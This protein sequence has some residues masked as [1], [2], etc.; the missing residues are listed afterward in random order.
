MLMGCLLEDRR[1]T[2]NA[3][4]SLRGHSD[5]LWHST[6]KD[7]SPPKNAPKS[8]CQNCKHLSKT[9]KTSSKLRILFFFAS[10]NTFSL[11]WKILL[12]SLF[13]KYDSIF[14]FISFIF[15]NAFLRGFQNNAIQIF[16][17]CTNHHGLRGNKPAVNETEVFETL[18][19]NTVWL[20]LCR[21]LDIYFN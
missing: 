4:L 14:T 9:N 1:G 15:R 10:I 7:S 16:S 6:I 12:F 17:S 20:V 18:E 5:W 11:K 19:P 2:A 8:Y 13:L 3:K 21:F